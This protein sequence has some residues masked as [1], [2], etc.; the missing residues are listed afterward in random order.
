MFTRAR[1]RVC[2]ARTREFVGKYYDA[3]SRGRAIRYN[4]P[5]CPGDGGGSPSDLGGLFILFVGSSGFERD[6]IEIARVINYSPERTLFVFF[7]T[8]GGVSKYGILTSNS[9]ANVYSSET[10]AIVFFRER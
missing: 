1:A 8:G 2:T 10:P 9:R 5:A 4:R 7:L 6:K 3:N